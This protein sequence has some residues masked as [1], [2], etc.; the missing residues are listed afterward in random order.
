MR[1]K[2]IL[3]IAGIVLGTWIIKFIF[4]FPTADIS[5]IGVILSVAS[6]LF[7]LLAGFYISVLWGRYT[8]IRSLQGERCSAGLMLLD[9]A[10]YFFK[11]N[12]KF[13]K[14]FRDRLEAT[15]IADE[16]IDWNEGDLEEPFYRKIGKSFFLL[17]V[18]TPKDESYFNAMVENHSN[19]VRT[20]VS[21]NTLYCERLSLTDWLLFALLTGVI[22]SSVLLLDGSMFFYS[23]IILVFPIIVFLTLSVIYELNTLRW[24]R[25]LVT[26]EPTQSILDALEVKRFYLGRDRPYVP[27]YLSSFRTEK[28]LRDYALVV[29]KEVL[30]KR[31]DLGKG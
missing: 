5:V 31:K 27:K 26:V 14:D 17:S 23:V 16:T 2:K 9:Y 25:Q 7:G 28:T 1:I 12:K 8:E 19:Y 21:M 10:R 24:G 11:T 22:G 13:E 20:T 3:V 29:Y 6:I 15:A 18:R 30:E 4:H